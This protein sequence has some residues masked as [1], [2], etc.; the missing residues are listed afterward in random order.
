MRTE[1]KSGSAQYPRVLTAYIPVTEIIDNAVMY[2]GDIPGNAFLEVQTTSNVA[3][4]GGV[5]V[6]T[7]ALELV[8]PVDDSQLV[9]LG[10]VNLVTGGRQ[11]VDH[12]AVAQVT[13]A[14][15]LKGTVALTDVTGKSDIEVFLKFFSTG[16]TDESLT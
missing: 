2:L 4:T 14:S 12:S 13:R 11:T 3:Y 9:D 15:R 7:L 6:A 8:D 10:S 1:I 5:P 16:A